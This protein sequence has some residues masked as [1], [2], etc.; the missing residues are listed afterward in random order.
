MR[1]SLG[2]I[3]I[4]G[5][6]LSACSWTQ[7]RGDGSHSGLNPYAPGVDSGTVGSL[8][9]A[10]TN[11]TVPL[12][13]E[14]VTRDGRAFVRS[15]TKAI[16]G[17]DLTTGTALWHVNATLTSPLYQFKNLLN[18][19][20]VGSG[21]NATV[22]MSEFEVGFDPQNPS[23]MAADGATTEIDPASGQVVASI[24]D[25]DD[26]VRVEYGGWTSWPRERVTSGIHATQIHDLVVD[27]PPGELGFVTHLSVISR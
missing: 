11:S 3:A 23:F 17:F 7:F 25:G 4:L 26:A 22:V 19:T 12:A 24:T 10:W 6:A 18:P 1:R 2:V 15:T 5:L 8:A 16:Y 13:G 21:A 27:A 9:P 14:V 20:T